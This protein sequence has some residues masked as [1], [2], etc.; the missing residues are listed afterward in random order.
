MLR[1]LI[2]CICVVHQY[3]YIMSKGNFSY[4]WPI[5]RKVSCN[6]VL[7]HMGHPVLHL[8]AQ[9]T[10]DICNKTSL[11]QFN[12][13][14]CIWAMSP[15]WRNNI[16]WYSRCHNVTANKWKLSC[17][18]Y[19]KGISRIRNVHSYNLEKNTKSPKIH[20]FNSDPIIKFW[21]NPDP[22]RSQNVNPAGLYR[23][24]SHFNQPTL[25]Q[26]EG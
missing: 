21:P 10:P 15:V 6:I 13:I 3:G 18:P 8:V 14:A 17:M 20:I 23:L 11:I 4:L 5:Q 1:G 24:R 25:E 12:W 2:F 26:R 22:D 19:T 9:K 16:T 7:E